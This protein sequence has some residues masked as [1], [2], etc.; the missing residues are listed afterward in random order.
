MLHYLI[1]LAVAALIAYV[2]GCC[3]GCLLRKWFGAEEPV[4]EAPRAP[5]AKPATAGAAAVT[6]AAASAAAVKLAEPRA[7]VPAT[8]PVAPRP[9]APVAQRPAPVPVAT[10]IVDRHKSARP[11]GIASA[12]GG[13]ADDLLRISGVGP[14]NQEI[15]HSL[16]IYHFDQIAKWTPGEGD[17]V[18]DHMKFNGRIAREEWI[19]QARLLA[20]GNESEFARLYGTG[21]EGTKEAGLRTVRGPREVEA[22]TVSSSADTSGGKMQRP[23][24]ISS[25]RGGKAD[26]LKRISG[27]GPK[28]EKILHGLGFFHFDQ[29]A[30]WTQKEIDWVEDH[31]RFG[32]RI[33]REEWPKQARLLADGKEAEFT[34][35][36]GT[37]GLANKKGETLSG[38]RTRKS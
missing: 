19:N 8:A 11:M 6:A 36:Y 20:V 5:A 12:R 4:V 9:V 16:G 17:W 18:D 33:T 22:Q 21:G 25:A 29:I 13:K 1:E 15:L 7:A 14:K 32:G 31:L 38:S 30:E 35:L 2:L 34:K 10:P 26:D 23:K 37:G 28:N 3:L 27:I 24:G